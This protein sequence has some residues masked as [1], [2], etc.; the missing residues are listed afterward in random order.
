MTDIGITTMADALRLHP[1][2]IT[3]LG[4]DVR[5][6]AALGGRPDTDSEER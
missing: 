3:V 2:D 6:T 1:S 5:I 4:E